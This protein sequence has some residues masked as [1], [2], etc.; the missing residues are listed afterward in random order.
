MDK[1]MAKMYEL[2][3][4]YEARAKELRE[5][6]KE[7]CEAFNE[8]DDNMKYMESH[9]DLFTDKEIEEIYDERENRLADA[10]LIDNQIDTIND[11]IATLE[12]LE[13]DTHFIYME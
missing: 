5:M 1:I 4:M 10:D 3:K 2:H 13:D 11:I 6:A 7:A 8:A 12:S 9:I